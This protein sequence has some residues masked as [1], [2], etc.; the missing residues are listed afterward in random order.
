MKNSSDYQRLSGAATIDHAL[1]FSKLEILI[2]IFSN[3][4][5][6]NEIPIQI[7]NLMKFD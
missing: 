2:K 6:P 7:Q 3:S 1:E 4:I 5:I